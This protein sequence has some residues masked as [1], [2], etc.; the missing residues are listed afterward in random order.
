MPCE[1]NGAGGATANRG[2]GET[3]EESG[4]E[5]SVCT[6]SRLD[7]RQRYGDEI[8]DIAQA[9]SMRCE[10][11]GNRPAVHDIKVKLQ[12][13]LSDPGAFALLPLDPLTHALLM[14]PAWRRFRIQSLSALT[15]AQLAECAKYAL[16]HFSASTRPIDQRAEL[17]MTRALLDAARGWHAARRIRLV[18][19]A[20]SLVFAA[21]HVR[22]TA[23]IRQAHGASRNR[24]G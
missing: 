6:A 20:L 2:H 13:F 24:A 4:M 19:A 15:H 18:R 16:D 23:I 17:V 7:F 8:A 3:V 9:H 5:T 22:A 21:D 10:Q 11:G 14:D 1:V 12:S